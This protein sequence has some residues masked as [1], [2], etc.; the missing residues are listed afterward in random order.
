MPLARQGPRL[1]VR[2]MSRNPPALPAIGILESLSEEA[3]QAVQ[4]AASLR[5]PEIQVQDHEVGLQGPERLQV[6][7]LGA[8]HGGHGGAVAGP[9][10]RKVLEAI[11]EKPAPAEP[12]EGDAGPGGGD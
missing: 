9:I 3:R 10:A 4:R 2:A 7:I 12:E 8:P 5:V 11:F 6:R 1:L